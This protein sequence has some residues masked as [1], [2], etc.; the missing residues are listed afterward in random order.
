MPFYVYM[1]TC[2]DGSIYTGQADNLEARLVA[3]QDGRFRGYIYKR[4]PVRL[5]FHQTF[6]TRE[7]AILAERE[8]KGWFRAKKLALA[9]G[10]WTGVQLLSLRMTI[11]PVAYLKRRS[12]A[13]HVL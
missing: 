1:V 2:S 13:P 3:H 4:R 11:Q 5:I 9:S 6:P 12:C 7:E 8:I 10:D